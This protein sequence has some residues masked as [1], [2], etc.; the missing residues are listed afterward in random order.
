[1]SYRVRFSHEAAEIIRTV[2]IDGGEPLSRKIAKTVRL[3]QENPRHPGLRSHQYESFTGTKGERIW[4]S[5]I[6]NRTPGAWRI[7]WF[8][9]PSQ[10]DITVVTLGKHPD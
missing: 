9:G 3:L 10:G 4:E 5:Y 7:W 6:E 2:A 1:M 8:Y